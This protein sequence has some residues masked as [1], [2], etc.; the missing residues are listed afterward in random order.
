MNRK[1][2]F[3]GLALM[4]LAPHGFGIPFASYE[5]ATVSNSITGIANLNAV[6]VNGNTFVCAGAANAAVLAVNTNAYATYVGGNDPGGYLLTPGAWTNTLNSPAK[7]YW[8]NCLA[9]QPNGF[10]ASGASNAVFVSADGVN[11]TNWGTVLPAGNQAFSVDGLAYNALSGTFAAA[12]AVYEAS[13]APNPIAKNGWQ[14]AGFQNQSFAESFRSVTPFSSSNMAL[15]GILGDIRVSSDGGKNWNVSQQANLNYPSLLSAASDGGLDLVCAGDNSLIEV[16]TNGGPNASSWLFQTNLN[17]GTTG[18]PTNFNAVTYGPSVN[19]FFAGGAVG[20]NG[21]IVT[22][23]KTFGTA[24]WVWTRQ[25]NVWSLQSGVLSRLTGNLPVLNGVCFA[26]SGL[27]QG[28]AMFVGDS[29]TVVIGGV[30]PLPPLNTYG[31]DITNL[32]SEP[33]LNSPVGTNS[34][35]NVIYDLYHPAGVLTLDWYSAQT[36]GVELA[37]NSFVCQPPASLYGACGTYTIWAQERD[38]RTG[39]TSPGRT[40]FVFTIVPGPPAD[41][42]SAT[43]CGNVNGQFGMCAT[44]PMSVTVVTNAANPPG[45]IQVNWYDANTNLV[46]GGTFTNDSDIVTFAPSVTPG[47]YTYYAQATNPATR[48]ASGL[49]PLTFQ[50]NELPLWTSPAPFVTNAL[51]TNPQANLQIPNP[52]LANLGQITSIEPGAIIAY[53]WYTNGDPTV[54]TFENP[55]PP[56]ALTDVSGSPGVVE[57]A[58]GLTVFPFIPTNVLCGTYT[59]YVRARVVDP[60]FTACACESTNL[61]PVTF[62]LLPP[63]PS[64]AIVNWTNVLAGAVQANAPIWVDLLT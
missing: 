48:L 49:I 20:A 26:N 40:P 36:G 50:E 64:D 44:T 9:A 57:P 5:F 22:A 29:G 47:I 13:W 55:N 35:A 17:I 45:T 33:Q 4:S 60:A 2:L 30:A 54:A 10:I 63:A 25:T 42:V 31:N 58:S 8:L 16:S 3:W 34:A 24:N 15:C 51:L 11:W 1:L 43:N 53:D 23:I 7:Y 59:Y 56:F 6:A 14:P 41:A 19:Q 37:T 21:V 61:I 12:L 39:F 28:I 46:A 52:P 62:V 32:L 27:F 18:G 38:L